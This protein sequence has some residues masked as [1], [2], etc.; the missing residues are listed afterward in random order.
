MGHLPVR[1]EII[2]QMIMHV[3]RYREGLPIQFRNMFLEKIS[4]PSFSGGNGK[5]GRR[6]LHNNVAN[7]K[8]GQDSCKFLSLQSKISLKTP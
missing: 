7:I 1:Q 8:D 2:P 5:H 6:N 3:G 4:A